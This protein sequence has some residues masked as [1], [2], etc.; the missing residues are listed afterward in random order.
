[1]NMTTPNMTSWVVLA[2]N[3]GPGFLET[4]GPPLIITDENA[5]EIVAI[6][7]Q[8]IRDVLASL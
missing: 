1:M 6:L 5:D 3:Q 8:S 7:D 4:L 2:Q